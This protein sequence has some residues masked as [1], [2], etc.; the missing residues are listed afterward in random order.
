M[1]LIRDID[2]LDGGCLWSGSGF[3]QVWIPCLSTWVRGQA[4]LW[5]GTALRVSVWSGPHSKPACH[6]KGTAL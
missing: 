4:L 5:I 1:V 2:G 3:S 6:R